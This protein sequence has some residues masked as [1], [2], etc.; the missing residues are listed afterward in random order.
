[1]P[2]LTV[3]LTRP[4]GR[5]EGLAGELRARGLEV[6]VEPLVEIE[7]LDTGPIDVGGLRLG[8]RDERHR[9]ATPAGA[10]ARPA[11]PRRGDRSCDGRRL[12]LGRR[13]RSGGV[14]AGGAAGGAAASGRPRCSSPARRARG[15]SSRTSSAR[16]SSRSTA[17]RERRP[18]APLRGRPRRARL[19]VG[20]ALARRTRAV[21]PGRLDRTGDD[22]GGRRAR[23]SRARRGGDADARRADLGRVARGAVASARVRHVPDR[24][25]PSGR[26]RRHVPRRDQADRAG[27]ADHRHHARHPAAG[28]A[29]G[30]A[31]AREHDR[32]TCRSGCISPSSTRASA[33]RGGR[34]RC[35]TRG[36]VLRRARQ[37]AARSRRR[38][39]RDRRRARARQSRYAL[40]TISRTFHGRDL[41]APAAAH[42]AIG[43]PLAELGPPI[44]P[45]ALVRLDLPEPASARRGSTRRALRRQ[46]RQHRPQPDARRTS[47][48]VGIVPGTQ[49]ELELGGRAVLRGRR[50]D[51]RRRQAGRRDPLRGQLPEHVG[52]DQPRQ[53]REL[54]HAHAGPVDP[55]P[56]PVARS[57]RK[58]RPGRSRAGETMSRTCPFSGVKADVRPPPASPIRPLRAALR[59]TAVSALGRAAILVVRGVV[60]VAGP[61]ALRCSALSHAVRSNRTCPAG[62]GRGSRGRRRRARST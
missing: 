49:V 31:R 25:R 39:G 50:A 18:A 21:D 36:P 42:L 13:P 55:H 27:R 40:E 52:R 12:G 3:V 9:R 33:G 61:D 7:P 29:A 54:L 17:R 19:A 48:E 35:V 1:M 38:A 2:P 45:D 20:G 44:D 37:R 30:R 59:S 10:D 14:H 11:A 22:P 6:C 5:N 41:F 28:G 26:L 47:S 58:S 60:R 62:T 15:R 34:S 8:D 53:R 57:P 56:P 4:E 43:V 51:V 32:R 23:H 16:T 24:L 46:L